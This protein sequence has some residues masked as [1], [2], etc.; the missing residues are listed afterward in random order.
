MPK[1]YTGDQSKTHGDT[2][3]ED[4]SKAGEVSP[5][6]PAEQRT[7]SVP[8]TGRDMGGGSGTAWPVLTRTNYSSWS[9][10]MCV[11]LQVR[12]LW[13]VIESPETG[14]GDYEDDRSAMEAILCV[15]PSEMIPLLAI[16]KT[17]KE[18]WD[19]IA[20]IR[21]G[22]DRVCASKTHNLRK[23]YE[24]IRFKPG[25]TIDEFGMRL[26]D[27]V[28][29]MEVLGDPVDDKK[30]I[31]KYL[32]VV[33]K[34]YKQMACSIE[35]VLDLSTMSIEVLTGRLKVCEEDE[36]DDV[37]D[38]TSGGKLLLT[39]EQWRARMKNDGSSGSSGGSAS[40]RQGRNKGRRHDG[41]RDKAKGATG[42]AQKDDECRYCGKLGHLARDCSNKKRE[43]AHLIKE[44][45][46]D[47]VEATL[48]MAQL[49][50]ASDEPE[51]VGG[52]VFLDEERAKLDKSVKGLVRFGDN[53]IVEITSRDT[54]LVA[55][56]GDEHHA[57]TDMYLIRRLQTSNVSLG[58]L[59]KNGCPSSIR[60]GLMSPWDWNNVQDH[61]AG[62]PA[63]VPVCPQH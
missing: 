58:Q 51:C 50:L 18:A 56:R 40:C 53:S 24:A 62:H 49:C 2:P 36:D 4:T 48:M 23:E 28:H 12:H 17:A 3:P 54:V 7:F 22:A 32:H 35:S 9:L 44:G 10:L 63:S 43:E 45:D 60:N 13:D 42:G 38:G 8:R 39:E 5:Q 37:T 19:A 41:A 14:K 1:N 21:I 33:T 30:I 27:L 11:I 46:D 20:T 34:Q 25:E 61:A 29:Q 57:L 52:H 47:N 59:D 16:K 26:Q 6:S 55:V 31:L 15:V